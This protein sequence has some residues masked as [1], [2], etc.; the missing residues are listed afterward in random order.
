MFH[1]FQIF[2]VQTSLSTRRPFRKLRRI[3][4]ILYSSDEAHL[5]TNLTQHRDRNIARVL[6]NLN[7]SFADEH[8]PSTLVGRDFEET[9]HVLENR[10]DIRLATDE[11]ELMGLRRR[12][13]RPDTLTPKKYV[14]RDSIVVTRIDIE[15]DQMLPEALNFGLEDVS[16]VRALN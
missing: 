8:S 11:P 9:L 13:T 7:A 10:L 4:E 12:G 1:H 5:A 6:E 2:H 14:S 15:Q 16:L 3:F